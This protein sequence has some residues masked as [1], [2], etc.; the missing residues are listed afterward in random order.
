MKVNHNLGIV[1]KAIDKATG[2]LQKIN[3]TISRVQAP[4]KK[5]GSSLSNVVDASGFS[6]LQTG[7]AGLNSGMS[8]VMNK[9]GALATKFTLLGGTA[10]FAFKKLFVD[11]ASQFEQFS[12]ILTTLLGSSDKA[13]KAMDWV[14]NFAAKTPYEL[15][16]VTE[17]FVKLKSYGIDPQAGALKSVGDAAAAMGKP[18]SQMVEALADAQSGEFTRLKE[19]IGGTFQT[20]GNNIAYS[21]VDKDDNERT[22]AAA[23]NDAVALQKMVLKAFEAKGYTGAMDNLSGTWSGMLSNLAD[24]W[25]RFA[26]LVMSSGV[27]DFMKGKLSGILQKLNEMSDNGKLKQLAETFG[28]KLVVALSATWEALKQISAAFMSL[29]NVMPKIANFVGGWGNLLKIVALVMAGPLLA[30]I[31]GLIA[32]VVNLGI[33]IGFTP[34]GWF[35]AGMAAIAAISI[36]VIKKWQAIKDFFASFAEA[37]ANGP[38]IG[39]INLIAGLIY[40]LTGIDLFEIGRKIM[41]SLKDGMVAAWQKMTE[42]LQK[43]AEGFMNLIPDSFKTTLGIDKTIQKTNANKVYTGA[44]NFMNKYNTSQ[45]VK[46]EVVIKAENLP[47]GMQVSTGKTQATSTKLDLGYSMAGAL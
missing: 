31:A 44:S 35:L 10:G 19:A 34:I 7:F 3:R 15:D 20:V 43:A 16:E 23:K 13:D 4:F 1:I 46:T 11:T 5:I 21:F 40:T 36:L 8:N 14:S 18:L 25:T 6:K 26:N 17:A 27:F 24:I 9:T 33:A 39:I 42:W 38:L 30:A 45:A 29:I 41:S 28:Q 37:F 32:A 47:K 12:T 22:F 2:P